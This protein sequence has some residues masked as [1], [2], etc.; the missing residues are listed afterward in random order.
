M[1]M[2]LLV[3]LVLAAATAMCLFGTLDGN[4]WIQALQWST[5]VLVAGKVA[6][7]VGEGIQERLA[8]KRR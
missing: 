5:G 3:G 8:S 6:D 4:Q 1:E 7:P 2:T